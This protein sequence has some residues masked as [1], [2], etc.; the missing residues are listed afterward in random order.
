MIAYD[1]PA[2][3]SLHRCTSLSQQGLIWKL[4]L[5]RI[6]RL[7]FLF[8]FLSLSFFSSEPEYSLTTS[9]SMNAYLCIY[10]YTNCFVIV[11]TTSTTSVISSMSFICII[12]HSCTFMISSLLS[13]RK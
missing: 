7:V 2:A 9:V 5:S 1:E 10:R 3:V 4:R 11:K 8:L 13:A 6:Y 12:H